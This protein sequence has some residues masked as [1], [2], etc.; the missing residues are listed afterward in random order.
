MDGNPRAV[1]FF[2][3]CH[4]RDHIGLYGSGAFFDLGNSGRQGRQ[5]RDL[6]PGQVCVVVSYT[7][8][9]RFAFRWYSFTHEAQ[10]PDERDILGR[11]FFGRLL[12]S[13][14][15]PKSKAAHSVRYSALFKRTGE[16]KQGSVF[17][18]DVPV[19]KRPTVVQ[20]EPVTSV[21][22]PKQPHAG[23]GFGDPLEN[24][25]VEVAAIRAVK[26]TY[27]E[28]GWSVRSVEREKCGFDLVCSKD[29]VV[30]D[31]EVKGVRGTQASFIITAGEVEQ[32]HE[33][34]RFFLVVVT[35]A[36]ASSRKITKYSGK[37]FGRLFDLSAIQYRAV[38]RS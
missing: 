19:S 9:D 25:A 34:G 26:R 33:N 29:G 1:C 15:L 13:E 5:A 35:S 18:Q 16:L 12:A 6:I 28:D 8:D 38:L 3:N 10:L 2:N 17:W 21:K 24:K 11:V 30:E 22:K 4:N 27:E 14:T 7:E 37:E 32:A 23:A 20:E 36:L 31:V